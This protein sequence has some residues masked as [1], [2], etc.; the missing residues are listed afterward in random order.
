MGFRPGS[1][2]S[3][4]IVNSV[5]RTGATRFL[6]Q[7]KSVS[8]AIAGAIS[9]VPLRDRRFSSLSW[10]L[11][12][13]INASSTVRLRMNADLG[14]AAVAALEQVGGVD[15]DLELEGLDRGPLQPQRLGAIGGC[16]PP[17]SSAAACG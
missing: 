6:L 4:V 3:S 5:I 16:R 13:E 12:G 15:L 10:A 9:S 8:G 11:V 2:A 14:G 17:R 7:T 1:N